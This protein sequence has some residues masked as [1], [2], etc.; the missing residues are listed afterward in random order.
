MQSLKENIL[1]QYTCNR[2]VEQISLK[3]NEMI[4]MEAKIWIFISKKW[5]GKSFWQVIKYM[6]TRYITKSAIHFGFNEHTAAFADM[7][8]TNMFWKF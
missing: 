5:M 8:N 6:R 7:T 3:S 1:I 2:L 4:Y